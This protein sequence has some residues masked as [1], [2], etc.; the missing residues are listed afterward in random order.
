MDR[1]QC[2]V[3]AGGCPNIGAWQAAA[4]LGSQPGSPGTLDNLAQT[5]KHGPIVTNLYLVL[6]SRGEIWTI[7]VPMC[8]EFWCWCDDGG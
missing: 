8:G 5:R 2:R 1:A 6:S 4:H 7:V 3:R